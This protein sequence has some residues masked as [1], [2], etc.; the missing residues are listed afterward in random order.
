MNK[1]RKQTI[2]IVAAVLTLAAMLGI[3]TN[4][5]MMVGYA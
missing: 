1:I 5:L 4:A 2:I 3:I